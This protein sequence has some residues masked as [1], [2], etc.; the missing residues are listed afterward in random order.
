MQKEQFEDT[1][2][3]TKQKIIIMRKVSLRK[4]I[5]K[6]IRHEKKINSIINKQTECTKIREV[7]S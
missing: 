1:R 2:Y 4:N 3:K 6:T 5:I 7:Y